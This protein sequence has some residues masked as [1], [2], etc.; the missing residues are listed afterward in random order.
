MGTLVTVRNLIPLFRLLLECFK[1]YIVMNKQKAVLTFL[2][3]VGISVLQHAVMG[4]STIDIALRTK[5]VG[6]LLIS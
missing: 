6:Y 3:P 1:Q 4:M 2:G 5:V